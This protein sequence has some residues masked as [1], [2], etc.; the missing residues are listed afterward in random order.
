[1]I[2]WDWDRQFQLYPRVQIGDLCQQL[3]DKLDSVIL[4]NSRYFSLISINGPSDNL[5]YGHRFVPVSITNAHFVFHFVLDQPASNLPLA[6][7]PP[8][9]TR[10][11]RF[12]CKKS[13]FTSL[14]ESPAQVLS[15]GLSVTDLGLNYSVLKNGIRELEYLYKIIG[16]T[17]KLHASKNDRTYSS[18]NFYLPYLMLSPRY[19]A[20]N[21]SPN[22]WAYNRYLWE[23]FPNYIPE[24]SVEQAF[25]YLLFIHPKLKDRPQQRASVQQRIRLGR[26]AQK[27]EREENSLLDFIY[28][29]LL[30]YVN[31]AEQDY[32]DL[33][34]TSIRRNNPCFLASFGNFYDNVNSAKTKEFAQFLAQG[35]EQSIKLKLFELLWGNT[36]GFVKHDYR[37]PDA[38]RTGSRA[39]RF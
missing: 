24:L 10:T 36:H 32:T 8:V 37:T 18:I 1:M 39:E 11:I 4:G 28:Q 2:P 5:E 15:I 25:Y 38:E 14:D 21:L 31:S 20:S 9:R 19:V 6:F 7:S 34:I 13:V 27:S 30:L 17:T 12:R 35:T 26:L 33:S 3:N 23:D 29:S 22:L 16:P